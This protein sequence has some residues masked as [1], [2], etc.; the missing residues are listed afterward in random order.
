MFVNLNSKDDI[1]I[2][3][4]IHTNEEIN[5]PSYFTPKGE[6]FRRITYC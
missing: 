4:S 2:D 5:M 3:F 6:K 1:D